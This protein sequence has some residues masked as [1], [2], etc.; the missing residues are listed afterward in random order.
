M[1]AKVRNYTIA[2]AVLGALLAGLIAVL[3]IFCEDKCVIAQKIGQF[4]SSTPAYLATRINS[5]DPFVTVVFFLYWIVVGGVFGFLAGM[6]QPLGK[7]LAIALTVILA[8]AHAMAQAEIS[9]EIEEAIQAL[10]GLF[11]GKLG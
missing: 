7:A 1:S 5:S 9:R 11:S 3:V 6:K 2:G 8:I 4:F 10:T